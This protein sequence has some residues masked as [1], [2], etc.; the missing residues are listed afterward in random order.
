MIKS[1]SCKRTAILILTMLFTFAMVFAEASAPA[2]AA[3][4][5]AKVKGI[6]AGTVSNY[7]VKVSWKKV[8][9]AKKYQVCRSD[10]KNGKYKK[11]ATVTGT[12]FTDSALEKGTA[13]YYR[14]RASRGKNNGAYSTIK[15]AVTKSSPLCDVEVDKEAKTVTISAKVNGK[16]FGRST[17]HLM[18]DQNGFN[19]GKAMLT[20][21][22][23]PDDLYNGLTATG[24]VSWSKSFGK[25]L[26]DGEKNTVKNAENKKYSKLDISISWDGESHSLS[27]CLTTVKGGNKA[28]KIDMI[29]SGNPGAAARTPSGCMVC[30][31]SCY[32][33]MAANSAYG[34][35]VIDK[36]KPKLFA[37]PDVMPADGT[38]VKVI[39]RIK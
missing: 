8:K 26:K 9:D 2:H 29:F 3:G 21:Y 30:M 20:S 36:G 10:K 25:I 1:Y 17:R 7:S 4:K 31:D 22:C 28:P 27:E 38:V 6:K 33:G 39:F 34:L 23:S 13:Y 24:G 11:I 14:V 37:R 32:I 35:C 16:Y 18:V 15:R 19:K 5:L 12:S